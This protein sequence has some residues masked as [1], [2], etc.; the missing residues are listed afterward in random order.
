MAQHSIPQNSE[1][2]TFAQCRSFHPAFR[3]NLFF[4]LGTLL[5]TT[6]YIQVISSLLSITFPSFFITGVFSK[7]HEKQQLDI[8]APWSKYDIPCFNVTS[9]SPGAQLDP[10]DRVYINWE[11]LPECYQAMLGDNGGGGS[12]YDSQGNPITQWNPHRNPSNPSFRDHN[13]SNLKGG[14]EASFPEFQNTTLTSLPSHPISSKPPSPSQLNKMFRTFT[15]TLYSNPRSVG[16][17]VSPKVKFDHNFVIDQSATNP[18]LWVV[19]YLTDKKI[20]N[21]EAFY[22]RVV[23]YLNKGG[24]ETSRV[25]K[26]ENYSSRRDGNTKG[27]ESFVVD[28]KTSEYGYSGVTGPFSINPIAAKF[29]RTLYPTCT[30]SSIDSVPTAHNVEG[31]EESGVGAM[32][33]NFT[34]YLEYEGE[35]EMSGVGGVS[36][37]EEVR[38]GWW[39][40][41]MVVMWMNRS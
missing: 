17:I 41:W 22:V 36:V 11:I 5:L 26:R 21:M 3:R 30:T 2:I 27:Q 20:E 4:P 25:D 38:M 6:T 31:D 1:F 28:K 8:T 14:K 37:N 13:K 7:S 16:Q 33:K 35:D 12:D 18:Y 24:N 39:I 29:P 10:N 32:A 9:P 19:P 34:G 15:I 40:G 23:G